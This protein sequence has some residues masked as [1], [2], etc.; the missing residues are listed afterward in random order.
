M[1]IRSYLIEPPLRPGRPE[2]TGARREL[3]K[4]V[5]ADFLMIL[6]AHTDADDDQCAYIWDCLD[7]VVDTLM[8]RGERESGSAQCRALLLPILTFAH[9]CH[10]P[11][12]SEA[13]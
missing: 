13:E 12:P 4:C 6:N 1:D 5:V 3:R 7:D 9:S 8:Q 11:K 10:I 2:G